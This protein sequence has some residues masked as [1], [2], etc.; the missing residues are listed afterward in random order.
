[1]LNC[2]IFNLWWSSY[3]I[4]GNSKRRLILDLKRRNL[5]LKSSLYYYCSLYFRLMFLMV[6][7]VILVIIGV[8]SLIVWYDV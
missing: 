8:V 5:N 2:F 4:I 1:M 6:K 3:R 7:I